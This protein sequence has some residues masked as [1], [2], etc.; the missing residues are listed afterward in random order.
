MIHVNPHL[1]ISINLSIKMF[2]DK[3]IE[4]L[5]IFAFSFIIITSVKI[6]NKQQNGNSSNNQ[7]VNFKN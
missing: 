4:V 2:F 1:S 6:K 7:T 3:L 5:I